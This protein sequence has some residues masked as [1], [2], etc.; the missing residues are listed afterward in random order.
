MVKQNCSSKML[1]AAFL[2][3]ILLP[4]T[5][6]AEDLSV[7]QII[8]GLKVSKSRSLSS[9]ERPA[10]TADDLAFVQRVRSQGRSLSVDDRERLAGIVVIRPKIDVDINFDY[11]SAALAPKSESQLNNLGKAL[12]APELA[13]SIITLSGYTDAKGSDRYNQRL[14]ERRAET[15]KRFLT[16]NYHIAPANLITVGYGKTHLK[17]PTDPF[18]PENR[19]TQVANVEGPEQAAR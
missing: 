3:L 11:N 9:P 15:V 16:E 14:S 1:A 7:Q 17:N 12:T 2:A 19:R 5:T 6:H 10:V 8:D 4:H 18:A 13:G